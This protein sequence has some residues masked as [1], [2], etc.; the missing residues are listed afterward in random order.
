M[1]LEVA[2]SAVFTMLIYIEIRFICA[3]RME[4]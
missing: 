3:M 4:I 1:I 2:L